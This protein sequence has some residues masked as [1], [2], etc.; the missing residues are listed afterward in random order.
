MDDSANLQPKGQSRGEC[1]GKAPEL[2]VSYEG[3][4]A[5]PD[6]ALKAS[7]LDGASCACCDGGG[8]RYLLGPALPQHR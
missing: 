1:T 8:G 4:P 7:I 6:V 3:W 2:I 5:W